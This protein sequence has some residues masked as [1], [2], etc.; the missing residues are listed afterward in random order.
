[1]PT[2]ERPATTEPPRRGCLSLALALALSGVLL[3]A[4][5][6]LAASTLLPAVAFAAVAAA[7]LFALAALHYLVWGYWLGRMIRKE[8]EPNPPHEPQ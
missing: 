1:M 2:I 4:F 6:V 5:V 3:L 7:L 8:E